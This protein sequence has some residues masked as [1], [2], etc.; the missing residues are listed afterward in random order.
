MEHLVSPSLL[1]ADFGNLERDVHI[2]NRSAAD[3]IHLDIMDGVFVPNISFG[4]PV[5]EHVKKVATK[6]LDVHLMIV[7]PDRY[8]IR[9]RD[10]GADILTVQYEACIHLQRTVTEIHN[11]GMKAGVALNPHTPVALLKNTLPYVDMIL[12]MTVNPGFG[13]QSFIMESYKK[14]GELSKM[15]D[16]RNYNVLIQ[17]DGGVDTT[18]A[19]RLIESGVDVLVAGN[20]VFSSDDPTETIRKLKELI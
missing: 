20:S 1:A 3:W 18:N 17:V 4:F 10:A 12:I 8:L 15:I 14:I 11:L 19:A 9:F 13:G 6:P 5:I 16:D 7:D 2:V